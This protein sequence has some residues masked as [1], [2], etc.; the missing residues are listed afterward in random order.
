[1]DMDPSAD[2]RNLMNDSRSLLGPLI[3]GAGCN[4]SEQTDCP[5]HMLGASMT[6]LQSFCAILR[7]P[8]CA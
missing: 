2:V 6:T 5:V 7:L 3:E 8:S 1:M 4:L